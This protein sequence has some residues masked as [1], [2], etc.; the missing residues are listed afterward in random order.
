L[1]SPANPEKLARAISYLLVQKRERESLVKEAYELL[2]K[3]YD[4]EKIIK[5]IEEEYQKLF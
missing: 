4:W 5:I 1:V 3:H 2:K